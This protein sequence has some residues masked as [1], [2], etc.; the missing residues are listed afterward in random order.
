MP[1]SSLFQLCNSS[2]ASINLLIVLRVG[3]CSPTQH[4]FRPSLTAKLRQFVC[5]KSS[6]PR[7]QH[8]QHGKSGSL[9]W[10]DHLG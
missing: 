3:H 6:G 9:F 10:A 4:A 1:I 8:W 7:H 5:Q 2:P